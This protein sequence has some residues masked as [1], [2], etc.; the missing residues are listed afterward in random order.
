MLL[1]KSKGDDAEIL[2]PVCQRDKCVPKCPLSL[3]IQY[4]YGKMYARCVR[5]EKNIFEVEEEIR[6]AE[7]IFC[8]FCMSTDESEKEW[9][10]SRRF[11]REV[12]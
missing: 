1:L 2:C 12:R 3:E 11:S 7:G 10:L 9:L 6:V 4:G 5:C 8:A